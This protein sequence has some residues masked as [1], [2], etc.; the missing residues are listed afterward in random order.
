[1]TAICHPPPSRQNKLTTPN[2]CNWHSIILDNRLDKTETPLLV[3]DFNLHY[4]SSTHSH[5]QK[6]CTLL[7]GH[8]PTQLVREFAHRHRLTLHLNRYPKRSTFIDDVLISEIQISSFFLSETSE[9][10]IHQPEKCWCMILLIP[11]YSYWN[12]LPLKSIF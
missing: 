7:S 9:T 1:M 3:S 5:D 6:V 2:V 4:D 8:G 11:G 12:S 10:C